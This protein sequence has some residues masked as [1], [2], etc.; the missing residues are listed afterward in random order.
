MMFQLSSHPLVSIIM[1][2]YNRADFIIESIESVQNQSWQNWELIIIDDGSGDNTEEVVK[3]INDGRIRFHKMNRTGIVGKLKNFGVSIARGELIA[4]L[5]SDDLWN[6][7]KLEKQVK[8]LEQYNEA[9]FCL[10]GGYN[11][12]K[13]SEPVEYFYK[14]KDGV[15]YDK[16]FNSIF[17]SEVTCF[18][19]ALMVRKECIDSA[20]LFKEKEVFNDMDFI[21]E[22]AWHFKAVILYE[23]LLYRRLHD[24][25]YIHTTWEKSFYEGAAIIRENKDRLPASVATNALFRLYINFG[26]ECLN[27]RQIKKA[28]RNFLRSWK[29]R[30]LSV[31]PAK[32]IGKALVTSLK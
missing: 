5:D 25:N 7:T 17:C 16:V 27:K 14:Q 8:A 19:Q 31:I 24:T 21:I 2:T 1:P 6:E 23:P 12:R 30:P 22:L 28:I 18:T 13:R 20:G 29:Y 10:T 26:E 11:F 4:F 15:R 3:N 9:G 32:K